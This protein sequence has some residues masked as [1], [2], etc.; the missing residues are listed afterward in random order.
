MNYTTRC[1]FTYS[2][3][4]NFFSDAARAPTF[5][6][7]VRTTELFYYKFYPQL[8]IFFVLVSECTYPEMGYANLLETTNTTTRDM[9]SNLPQ[10]QSLCKE[11]AFF[12]L[13]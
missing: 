8:Y 10:A 7:K 3:N 2:H 1:C 11:I 9:I 4:N 13:N 5:A 6:L 12:F